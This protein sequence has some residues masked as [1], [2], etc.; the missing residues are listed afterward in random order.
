MTDLT[1]AI[2]EA[3]LRGDVNTFRQNLQTEYVRKL[4]AIVE[5]E[6]DY[7]HTS[8]SMAL[9]QIREIERLMNRKRG[10]NLETQAHTQSIVYLIE[11]LL[12]GNA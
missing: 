12:E 1:D 11:H 3:D 4:I 7:D 10:G 9:F 5:D 2:F 8:R 6:T